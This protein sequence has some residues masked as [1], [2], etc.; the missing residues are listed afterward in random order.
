MQPRRAPHRPTANPSGAGQRRGNEPPGEAGGLTRR[1]ILAGAVAGGALVWTQAYR[2][3]PASAAAT[4]AAPPSFPSSIPL[5]QQAYQN[6]AGMIVIDSVWTCAPGSADDVVSL[7]NWAYANGYRLRPKGMSHNWSPVLLPAGSDGTGYVLVDTTQ[8]LTSVSISAGPPA[9]VTV[10]A[11]ATM[12][13]LTSATATAGYGFCAIPAPGD[14][15][16]GGALAINA[17][18]SAIPGAGETPLPGQS[19]GSL[20]NLVVSLTAVVWSPA[21]GQYVLRRFQRSDPDIRAFLAHL[22]RAFVTEVTLQVASNQ[23]LRCQSWVDISAADLFA[24]PALA[25]PYS[26]A[27]YAEGAGRVEAI[28]FPFTTTPW[29]KVWSIAPSQPWFSAKVSGP[30][31][32]SFTNGVTTRQNTFYGQVVDGDTTGTPSFE[33]IAISLVDTGLVFTGVWDIW[34]Q[35]QDVLLYVKPTTVR[36]VEAGFAVVTSRSNIQQVV[37]DFYTQY[38]SRLAYYQLLGQFPMNGP[39]EIRVTGLDNPAGS[40]VP[41]AQSPILSSV[42]PRPDHPGWDTAVWLDMGTLPVTPGFSQF[43]ADME[44]WIWSHYTGSYAA[45][46]PEWS[47][48]WACT[49]AGPWANA[50]ILGG[51]VPAAVSAGQAAGDGWSTAVALLTSYDP[52]AVF[53][54]PFLDTLLG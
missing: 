34:G 3:T 15:T 27:S 49:P 48:A 24:P 23:M 35:S 19:Y 13:A 32:Y 7:A 47:K 38:T 30:Y 22:G 17:H 26:F 14:I 29:L 54:S 36:I 43:Y 40:V 37:S 9:T 5:Y 44:A 25:G 10:Q 28:W 4:S 18:G 16:V 53:S 42:R 2:V 1:A 50:A 6:W 21:Q 45:V 51:S 46:R 12:D 33:S 31:N 20:S 11:G 41:G 39:V 8:Y 52:Y